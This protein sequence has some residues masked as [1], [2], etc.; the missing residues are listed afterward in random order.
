MNIKGIEKGIPNDELNTGTRK[1]KKDFT[2]RNK[3]LNDIT[4]AHTNDISKY[5]NMHAPIITGMGLNF[6]TIQQFVMEREGIRRLWNDILYDVKNVGDVKAIN[7]MEL[8]SVMKPYRDYISEIGMD[9]IKAVIMLAKPYDIKHKINNTAS[10]Y[11]TIYNPQPDTIS[12]LPPNATFVDPYCYQGYVLNISE[13]LEYKTISSILDISI[14]DMNILANI[15]NSKEM[16]R[17]TSKMWTTPENKKLHVVSYIKQQYQQNPLKEYVDAT[18]I[19]LANPDTVTAPI[20]QVIDF[21]KYT[22][23]E[24]ILAISNLNATISNVL[25][26][27]GNIQYSRICNIIQTAC[28][29]G[30]DYHN[31]LQQK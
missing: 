24:H 13:N 16:I 3:L 18:T 15:Y 10:S 28:G 22:V 14:R 27:F 2:N 4:V 1:N 23:P 12:S 8:R 21:K 29:G 25:I 31:I 9:T 11:V 20:A 5:I 26:N 19:L 6:D 7:I 30:A 17:K